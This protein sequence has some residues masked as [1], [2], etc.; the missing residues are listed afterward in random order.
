MKEHSVTIYPNYGSW[1]SMNRWVTGLVKSL[2]AVSTVSICVPN[3]KK[4]LL[5]W[6]YMYIGY[7]LIAIR[8]KSDLNIVVSE[9]S[10]Y[11]LLAI[12]RG[13]TIVICHDLHPLQAPGVSLLSKLRYRFSL[14]FLKKAD[15]VIAIS[16]YT[17]QI[18]LQTIKK[19]D[20]Q[21]VR[22]VNNGIEPFFKQ[23]DDKQKK[24]KFK[25][26]I[27]LGADQKIVLHVGN[28]N[29][30][31][32]FNS[33]LKAFE[34]NQTENLVVLKI[35][36]LNKV[37]Q[38]NFNKLKKNKKAFQLLNINDDELVMAYNIADVLVYPSVS[39]GFGWPIIE[40]MACGCPVVAANAGSIPEISGGAAILLEPH[41]HTGIANEI[42]EIIRD[43]E[44][45]EMLIKLGLDNAKRFSWSSTVDGI[46]R[47]VK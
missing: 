8:E 41:N 46:L 1:H 47:A 32:N 33:L 40:A 39:E 6:F 2:K 18:L 12:R 22:V 7:C 27:G 3:R 9:A 15:L 25:H 38:D 11:L 44:K 29:W 26:E 20:P 31:K 36:S 13:K 24:E 23:I 28:D 4:G 37:N 34:L 14:S 10:A 45:R 5:S 21:K 16:E 17:K 30:Y 35:G 19:I 43:V 42:D